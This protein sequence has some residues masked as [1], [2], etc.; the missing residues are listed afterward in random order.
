MNNTEVI[1]K[2]MGIK[3]P[4]IRY[5][6]FTALLASAAA[7]TGCGDVGDYKSIPSDLQGTWERTEE[8]WWPVPGDYYPTLVKGTLVIN[9]NSVIIRGPVQHLENFTR[10]VA[11]E[12][13]AEDGQLYIKDKG[14][15]QSPIAYIRWQSADRKDALLTI[16]GGGVPDETLKRIER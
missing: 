10:D 13:Y 4:V 11:I 14:A 2:T 12:S 3:N 5:A 9:Y 16:S 7:F 6:L 1:I 15:W 8:D